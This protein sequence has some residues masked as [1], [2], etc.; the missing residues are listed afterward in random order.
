M[1]TIGIISFALAVVA[2]LVLAVLLLTSWK[3]KSQGVFLISA[4]VIQI[5]WGI[6][7]II[8]V[9][10]GYPNLAFWVFV[11]EVLKTG[12]WL[13]F[14]GF[15]FYSVGRH[16]VPE[17]LKWGTFVAPVA[18]LAAGSQMDYFGLFSLG[19]QLSSPL[20]ALLLMMYNLFGIVAVEQFYRNNNE[21]NR[22]RVKF[23][24]FALGGLF[25]YDFFFY[26]YSYLMSEISAP[27]WYAKGIVDAAIVPF[28]AI[29]AARNPAWSLDVFVSRRFAFYTTSVIAAGV[30]LLL[31]SIGGYYVRHWGGSW[32]V[33][34]QAIFITAALLALFVVLFSGRVQSWLKVFLSKHFYSYKYDYRDEWLR[35][36]EV[37]SAP[38]G[39][40]LTPY[41]RAIKALAQIVES[42]SGRLWH[43][44]SDETGPYRQFADWHDPRSNAGPV[45][46][47]AEMVMF[48][49]NTG[50][51]IDIMELKNRPSKYQNLTLPAAIEAIRDAWLV[52]PL[53][54]EKRL[55][56]FVVLSLPRTPLKLT[57]EDRDLLKTVAQQDT[58]F[59][60]Q[61]DTAK[62]LA[63][64]QQFA[65][66]NRL[67][68]Y[69]VH[70]LN[71]MV[72]QLQLVTKNA[73][74]HRDNPAFMDDAIGTVS[75]AVAKMGRLLTQLKKGDTGEQEPNV[76][77]VNREIGRS[78][79]HL[80]RD[81]PAPVFKDCSE[82]LYV[83]INPDR[84]V[85]VIEHLVRNAQDAIRT[86]EGH[87][88][89]RL[90]RQDDS[91]VVEVQDD[92]CGM[93][94]DFLENRLFKPFDTTKGNAGMGIGVYQSRQL[95][96]SVGGTMEV[97]SERNKGTTI[98]IV[99]PLDV[100][101]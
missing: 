57:W 19:F 64:T 6:V 10:R 65:A 68:A 69:V 74:R 60:A 38:G 52:V 48:L 91:A 21:D 42:P 35:M 49:Q 71:N 80:S 79:K 100:R 95:I 8:A 58:I 28:I 54:N 63:E 20:L 16:V 25:A 13:Y 11:A 85:S 59:L 93:D 3:G 41:E 90:S 2:Q 78:L 14:I 87:V 32:G 33:F 40:Q 46:A 88:E 94:Q 22:W 73:E 99:L 39:E 15:I 27:L 31:M 61:M 67:S 36:M 12:A 77:E 62:K 72:A 81:T 98:R 56:G 47:D 50:W 26:G 4:A 97:S 96:N 18:V 44:E 75:N 37:L 9:N 89:V 7:N 70:D 101:H 5:L 84:F 43:R 17:L 55:D 66:F 29:S 82:K 34:L 76:I 23:L 83:A 53:I 51:I 45:G 24:C 92:G 1:Y 86:N 30:Y